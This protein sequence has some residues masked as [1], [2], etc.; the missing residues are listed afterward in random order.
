MR[1]MRM[2]WGKSEDGAVY[3]T[4]GLAAGASVVKGGLSVSRGVDVPELEAEET[5]DELGVVLGSGSGGASEGRRGRSSM[6]T[7]VRKRLLRVERGSC[8]WIARG[9]DF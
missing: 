4:A 8:G 3:V 6:G 2:P 1:W 5:G 7:E 9:R